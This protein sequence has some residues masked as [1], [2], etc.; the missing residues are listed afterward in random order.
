MSISYKLEWITQLLRKVGKHQL[1]TLTNEIDMGI[2][3]YY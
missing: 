1:W 3:K 2:I